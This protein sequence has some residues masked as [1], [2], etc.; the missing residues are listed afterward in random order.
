MG[1]LKGPFQSLKEIWIQLVNTKCCIIIIIWARICIVLHN[2]IIHIKGDNFDEKWR[3]CLV[4]TGLDGANGD[5]NEDDKP[6]DRLEQ[7]WRWLETPGQ[8]FRHKLMDDLFDSP[9]CRVECCP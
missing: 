7:A 8:H 6:E 1:M 9:S 3:E 2:L 5:T 4:R